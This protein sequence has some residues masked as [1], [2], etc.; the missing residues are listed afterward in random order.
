MHDAHLMLN[1]VQKLKIVMLSQEKRNKLASHDNVSAVRAAAELKISIRIEFRLGS[2]SHVE[3][4][5]TEASLKSTFKS[6]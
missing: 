3:S 6:S 2:L 4:N 1:W 5:Y